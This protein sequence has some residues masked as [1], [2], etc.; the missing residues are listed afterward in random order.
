[1]FTFD[2]SGNNDK[3]E[4]Y[5]AA[6]RIVEWVNSSSNPQ[7]ASKHLTLI[8]HSHGGNV[9]KI[10]KNRL[11]AKGWRV[12]IINIETPQRKDYESRNTGKGVY[13]NFYSPIDLVQYGG[14]LFQPGADGRRQ[15][16]VADKNVKLFE[17][18]VPFNTVNNT[19]KW[20]G[21]GVGH[22]LQNNSDCQKQIVDETQKAFDAE[23]SKPK[24]ISVPETT[25]TYQATV[26]DSQ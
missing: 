10:V 15:D 11:E 1:V 13:L 2:W 25:P 21:D 5:Y 16:P 4:R 18:T 3:F 20:L 17:I 26:T 8:G 7:V 6:G 14:A 24:E 22:S 9:N 23:N 12:D 19:F